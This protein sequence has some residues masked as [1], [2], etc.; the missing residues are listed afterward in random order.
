[1]DRYGFWSMA[2]EARAEF[3]DA[4]WLHLSARRWRRCVLDRRQARP[5]GP[6]HEK[7][8]AFARFTDPGE[9]PMTMRVPDQRRPVLGTRLSRRGLMIGAAAAGL[10]AVACRRAGY[11]QA[12][13]LP[14]ADHAIRIAPVSLEIAPGKVIKT[15]GYHGTVPGPLLRLQE[16]KPHN[17][18]HQ[19]FWVSQSN[20]LA[21]ALHSFGSGWRNRGG[22][23]NYSSRKLTAL[24]FCA[25]TFWNGHR[26]KN[27][28]PSR[29]GRIASLAYA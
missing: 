22:F 24:L 11:A 28:V 12:S 1:M 6:E 19:R 2:H 10:A 16:S 14:P 27:R 23:A 17:K 9:P 7:L 21:R 29:E 15:T 25:K 4:S 5:R 26:C 8:A 18:R 20:P 3:H 13:N